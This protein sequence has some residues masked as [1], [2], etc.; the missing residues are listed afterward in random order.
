V[1]LPGSLLRPEGHC[2]AHLRSRSPREPWQ[3]QPHMRILRHFGWTLVCGAF[4]GCAEPHQG[5]GE[6]KLPDPGADGVYSI[7]WPEL[8]KG[9]DRYISIDLGP[10][11]LESCRKVSPKFPFDSAKTRAQDRAALQALASCLNHP[12]MADR[13]LNLVGRADEKGTDAYNEELGKK[14]AERIRDI[15][16][17]NGVGADRIRLGSAGEAGAVGSKPDYSAGYDRRVDVIIVGGTHAP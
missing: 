15:L 6:A 16:V 8:G 12:S 9:A 11:S 14:R 3:L 5:G 13:T 17:K 7:D 10:D 4:L 2:A 1:R